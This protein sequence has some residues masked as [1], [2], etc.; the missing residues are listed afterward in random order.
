MFHIISDLNLN[1][2]DHAENQYIIGKN[3][4]YIIITGNISNQSKRTLIFAEKLADLYKTSNIIFN[5]GIT[6]SYKGEIDL[7]ED[8]FQIHINNSKNPY[9]NLYFPKGKVI[10]DYD[11]YCTIGWPNIL[12]SD[13]FHDSYF[14]KYLY[15]SYDQDI[16]ID[17]ILMSRMFPR[18]FNVDHIALLFHE[19]QQ[20][21]K[22]W[23]QND[24]GK[25]KILVTNL[26]ELSKNYLGNIKC[27]FFP[28]LDLSEITWI[29]G[30]HKSQ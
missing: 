6:E 4:E 17:D 14:A 28:E 3:P 25:E 2:M 18:F 10:G 11:F 21:V 15:I 1:Y 12:D 5:C 29:S 7:I 27:N 24:Q 26:D 19:E 13:G 9:K 23:L 30:K 8:G 22:K 16:Y 20:Q